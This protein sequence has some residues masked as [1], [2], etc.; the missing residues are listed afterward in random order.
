NGGVVP[1]VGSDAQPT[2]NSYVG[3]TSSTTSFS[4]FNNGNQFDYWIGTN[5]DQSKI[6]VGG[7]GGAT[8]RFASGP[9]TCSVQGFSRGVGRLATSDTLTLT[10]M[11]DSL[12]GRNGRPVR[13]KYYQ[14]QIVDAY[15]KLSDLTGLQTYAASLVNCNR[16]AYYTLYLHLFGKYL[17]NG[18]KANANACKQALLA[19]NTKDREIVNRILYLELMQRPLQVYA[20]NLPDYP[21]GKLSDRD[22]TSLASIAQS[23]TSLAP[24]ALMQLRLYCPSFS[25]DTRMTYSYAAYDT[26]RCGSKS[27]AIREGDTTTNVQSIRL[28]D[29]YPNPSTASTQISYAIEEKFES[30]FIEVFELVTGNKLARLQI[31]KEQ[32]SGTWELNTV[33]FAVGVYG[34]RLVVDGNTWDTKKLVIL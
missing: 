9:A 21:F 5:E 19:P 25:C 6:T 11:A 7:S 13:Q 32:P 4:I 33:N 22:S 12:K 17:A 8:L 30:A 3:Y 34:Y 10:E 15:E 1:D 28:G 26:L 14:K 31:S 24:A 2:G 23:G 18:D 27:P 29:A 16:E 20:S